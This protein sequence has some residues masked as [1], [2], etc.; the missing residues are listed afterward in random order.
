M[1]TLP[2]H[3][4][5]DSFGP[6][7]ELL[8]EHKIKYQMNERRSGEIVAGPSGVI[9]LILSAA[10]WG[11][12]ATVLVTFIKSRHGRKVT[13]TTKDNNIIHAEGITEKE[14]EKILKQSKN[15]TAID[16]NKNDN[17]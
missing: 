15:I 11:A 16:P 3:V 10:M 17:E 7:L 4:F 1:E 12:L 2:I 6:I 8:N 5:K 13:I 14:L 9:E